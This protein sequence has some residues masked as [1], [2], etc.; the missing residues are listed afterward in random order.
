MAEILQ[1]ISMFTNYGYVV[2]RE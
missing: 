2:F 1:M